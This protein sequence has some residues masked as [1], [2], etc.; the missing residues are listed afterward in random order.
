MLYESSQCTFGQVLDQQVS[1]W[2]FSHAVIVNNPSYKNIFRI[3]WMSW[4]HLSHLSQLYDFEQF[5]KVGG[6]NS[7]KNFWGDRNNELTK[8]K[9]C[10]VCW[11]W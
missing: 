10:L 6:N 11:N 5:G 9:R 7:H 4:K 2:G 3:K 8:I 1:G